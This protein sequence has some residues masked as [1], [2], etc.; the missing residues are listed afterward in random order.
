M[1]FLVGMM[2]KDQCSKLLS[3][4]DLKGSMWRAFKWG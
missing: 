1:S 4:D 3:G 2:L